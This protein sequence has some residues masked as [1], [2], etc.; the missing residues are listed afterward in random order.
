MLFYVSLGV[1]LALLPVLSALLPEYG[2]EI[3][4]QLPYLVPYLSC[5]GLYP[6]GNVNQT[7]PVF[8]RVLATETKTTSTKKD[9]EGN[10]QTNGPGPSGAGF[11]TF[12]SWV[13]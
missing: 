13:Q 3:I 2:C 11:E 12:N 6:T 7:K 9:Y 5:Q 8:V 10:Y 4:R 1:F